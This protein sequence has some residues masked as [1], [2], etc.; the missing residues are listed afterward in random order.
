MIIKAPP[1]D[2]AQIH[3]MWHMY[4]HI[5]TIKAFL[6]KVLDTQTWNSFIVISHCGPQNRTTFPG[7]RELQMQQARL[8]WS[9]TGGST[10]R[11][12]PTT[13]YRFESTAACYLVT[14]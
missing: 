7:H 11:H 10:K 9:F 1:H 8:P 12:F 3:P 4:I 6:K 2:R 14:G 5:K 13:V